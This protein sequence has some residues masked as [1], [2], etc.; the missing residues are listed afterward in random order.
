MALSTSSTSN[1][2][3]AWGAGK[4]SGHKLLP[5]QDSAAWESGQSAKLLAPLRASVEIASLLLF[6]RIP[7]GFVIKVAAGI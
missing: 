5:K 3:Q 6:K 1:S 7:E 2:S 4:L